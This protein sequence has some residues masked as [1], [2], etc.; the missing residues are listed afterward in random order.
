MVSLSPLVGW[1]ITW[2]GL[3]TCASVDPDNLVKD[4]GKVAIN[5]AKMKAEFLCASFKNNLVDD[6]GRYWPANTYS[7]ELQTICEEK[8]FKFHERIGVGGFGQVYRGV[9]TP[10]LRSL[11]LKRIPPKCD[12][13]EVGICRILSLVRNEECIHARL[14]HKSIAKFFCTFV[15]ENGDVVIAMELIDG[16]SMMELVDPISCSSSPAR[17]PSRSD[18]VISEDKNIQKKRSSSAED[19]TVDKI[20][21]YNEEGQDFS[22]DIALSREPSVED[23]LSYSYVELKRWSKQLVKVMSYLHSMDIIYA[24]VKLENLLIDENDDLRLIDFGLAK[25]WSGPERFIAGH[26]GTPLYMSPE[27]LSSGGSTILPA[28]DWYSV[29]LVFYEMLYKRDPFAG[30]LNYEDDIDFYMDCLTKH[31][32]Q[33]PLKCPKSEFPLM[34]D[35]IERLTAIRAEE[36]LGY[37]DELDSRA[38]DHLPAPENQ[39]SHSKELTDI[40]AHP[41]FHR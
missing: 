41:W 9:H 7:E 2:L 29:G 39:T 6:D 14:N 36:R 28:C 40:L 32:T 17:S 16:I 30:V 34:A 37:D 12:D 33:N 31:V 35:L 15:K 26:I 8:D 13:P 3:I 25:W 19:S 23:P 38:A 21:G 4:M 5:L 10:T 1:I 11:A 18:L 20:G 22:P 27:H 24:D